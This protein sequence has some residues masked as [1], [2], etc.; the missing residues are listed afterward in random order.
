[1]YKNFGEVNVAIYGNITI[2]TFDREWSKRS[3][4]PCRLVYFRACFEQ[5]EFL[6]QIDVRWDCTCDTY[7]ETLSKTMDLGMAGLN[8]PDCN[9]VDLT[10]KYITRIK[11]N[12]RSTDGSTC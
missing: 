4:V 6:R 5:S 11:P 3:Y 10:S 9:S 12:L 2:A 1:M 8:N 7:S